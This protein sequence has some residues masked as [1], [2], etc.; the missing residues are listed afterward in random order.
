MNVRIKNLDDYGRGIAYI[1]NKITFIKNALTDELIEYK[2]LIEK[3]KYN[4]A[5]INRIFSQNENRIQPICPYYYE[6]GGCNLQHLN[7]LYENEFKVEKVKNILKKF[8]GFEI[9]DIKIIS[10]NCYNYRNKITLTVKNG[11]LGLLKAKTN[12]LVEI[13]SC[14]LINKKLNN[15][16]EVLETIIKNELELEKICLKIGN[17]TDEVMISLSG[18]VNDKAPFLNICDSLIINKKVVTKSYITSYI[19][20]KKFHIRSDSFFQVN[21]EIVEKLYQEVIDNIKK[22]KSKNVLDL[23]CGVG[24]IGISVAEYV[25]NVIGVEITKEAIIDANEN[26]KINNIK[27]IEF[28]EGKVENILPS[29]NEEIDTVIVD[30]PR[31]GIDSI[32]RKTLI[33]NKYKNI[34]YISCD[35]ITLARDLK[36]LKQLYELKCIKLFNMFPRTHHVECFSVLHRKSLEK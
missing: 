9:N 28:K 15:L 35:P 22:I 32:T 29:I 8:A 18:K 10:Q 20:D 26:K 12:D 7:F 33:K 4:E 31:N 16:I 2:D 23:Y 19:K 17:K 14:N 11:K 34:I 5:E 1:N 3:R 36:E 24:T 21:D 6:C 27:N 13:K 30:P 25:E